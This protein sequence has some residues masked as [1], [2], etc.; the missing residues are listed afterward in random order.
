MASVQGAEIF[1]GL[2]YAGK[3]K[4]GS[5]K[6]GINGFGRIGRL[7]LRASLE[8]GAVVVA[9]NDPFIE[10]NYMAYMFK[11]DSTHGR[12]KG[13]VSSTEN[14]LVVNG[15]AI[16]VFK[17]K[18]SENIPWGES[19]A[20]YI[21]ESTGIMTTLDKA[22]THIKAGA[23]KVIISGPSEEA[24]LFVCGVNLDKYQACMEI[25][26]SGSCT[27]N[28][29]APLVKVIHNHFGIVEA[30]VTTVH[31]AVSKQLT[32]D[33]P[34]SKD[35]R[36]GRGALQNIIPATSGDASD[37]SKVIPELTGRMTG[38]SF[39]VPTP[40]VSVIDMTCKL[41][42]S[43][44]YKTIVDTVRSESRDTMKGIIGFT[45]EMLVSTDFV[46]NPCSSVFDAQ[47]GIAL[48]ETFVK[49]IAWYD[50]EYAYSCRVVA[51]INHIYTLDSKGG[52]GQ[53]KAKAG[54]DAKNGLELRKPGSKC[55]GCFG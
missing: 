2:P 55:C 50:N 31:S 35:R 11:Y 43:T 45:D 12:F 53:C 54:G 5:P 9:I 29:L 6:V 7:T 28:C 42:K 17:E 3:P 20:E 47:A 25:V 15:V 49:L 38:M 34:N 24:P 8:L 1:N 52:K 46:G 44:D 18:C 21:V 27:I 48:N 13:T 30:L 39:R 32:V 40:D 51:L 37:I 36:A 41:A 16:S 10:P 23:K 22:S 14:E 19:G 33:G 26:S 4:D